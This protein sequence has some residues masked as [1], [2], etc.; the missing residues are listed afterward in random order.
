MLE[1]VERE[2]NQFIEEEKVNKKHE[3]FNKKYYN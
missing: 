2:V 3:R 1:L